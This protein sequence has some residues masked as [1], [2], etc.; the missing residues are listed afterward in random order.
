ML[1]QPNGPQG[2]CITTDGSSSG[3]A[4]ACASFAGAE[5]LYGGSRASVSPSGKHVLL[6]SSVG[7]WSSHEPRTRAS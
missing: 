3:E 6:S 5:A 2:G 7:P 4:G 1:S